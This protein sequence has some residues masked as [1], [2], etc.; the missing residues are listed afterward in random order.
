MWGKIIP[1]VGRRP[2]FV[3]TLLTQTLY[4][5]VVIALVNGAIAIEHESAAAYALVFGLA[6]VFGVGDS[7]LES[8]IPAIIQSPTFWPVERDRDAANSNVRMWQ[9]LG[10][11]VQFGMGTA[12][13]PAQQAYF[14]FPLMGV[15]LVCLWICDK[16]Y[17]PIDQGSSKGGDGYTA[18]SAAY[19]DDD[20]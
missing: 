16:H 13:T 17:K 18:V 7:V 19:D 4:Y 2:L 20:A 11:A 15:A 3:V 5:C 9:S 10:F 8:Q 12:T 1:K 6:V 14:C